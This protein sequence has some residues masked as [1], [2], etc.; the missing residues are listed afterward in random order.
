MTGALQTHA[1]KHSL[2][3]DKLIFDFKVMPNIVEQEN[4]YIAHKHGEG[5]V[6]INM[7]FTLHLGITFDFCLAYPLPASWFVW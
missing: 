5:D 4:V 6:S 2:P 1:R 3:I 7:Q